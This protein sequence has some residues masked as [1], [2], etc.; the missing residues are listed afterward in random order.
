MGNRIA[1][2]EYETSLLLENSGERTVPLLFGAKVWLKADTAGWAVS[3]VQE[4][5]G[6]WVE[7]GAGI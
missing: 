6:I 2:T 1:L 7:N 4:W 3:L 5:R